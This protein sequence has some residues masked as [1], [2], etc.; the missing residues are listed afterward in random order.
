MTDKRQGV[1]VVIAVTVE[2]VNIVTDETGVTIVTD[3]T[4]V[5]I[6][7]DK[8]GMIAFGMNY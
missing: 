8:I 3:E 1:M 6:V 4:G 5:T 2:V 7:T